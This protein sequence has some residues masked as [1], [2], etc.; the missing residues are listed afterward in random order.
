MKTILI[1]GMNPHTIDYTNPE[2][3]P[4][5]TVEMVE[6]GAKRTLEK[7]K[8]MGYEAEEFLIDNG[9][10]DLSDLAKQLK[11]RH[12]SGVVVGNGIRSLTSNFILFEKIINTVHSNALESK[13]IFNTSPTNTDEAVKRWL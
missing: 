13:I 2:V 4:G 7:L 10:T 12:Y 8:A 6:Q 9:T 11:N 5:L 3:P 1:I